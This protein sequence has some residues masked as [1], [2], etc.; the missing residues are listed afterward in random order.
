VLA[1]RRGALYVVGRADPVKQLAF[2]V[3]QPV[4]CV[5]PQEIQA[6]NRE[7]RRA[8]QRRRVARGACNVRRNAQNNRKV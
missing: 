3:A 6:T 4:W 7:R 1:G 2:N 8:A 5:G